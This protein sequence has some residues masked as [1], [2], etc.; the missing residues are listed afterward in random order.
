[1]K[2]YFKDVAVFLL[3]GFIKFSFSKA[4][5]IKGKLCKGVLAIHG[6]SFIS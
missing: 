4:I 6:V 1:M 3:K 5:F 2:V